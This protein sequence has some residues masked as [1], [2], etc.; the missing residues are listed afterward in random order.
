MRHSGKQMMSVLPMLPLPLLP[1]FLLLLLAAPAFPGEGKAEAGAILGVK[2]GED[3]VS[4]FVNGKLFTCYKFGPDQKYPYFWPVNGP[5]SG[6]SVTTESSQPYPHH[7]SLF[8]GCDR[9]NGGNYWQEGLERGQ[10]VSEGPRIIEATG[11]RILFTDRCFWI[12]PGGTPVIEDI[13]RITVTAPGAGKRI[14]DFEI[15]LRPLKPVT[16]ERTNHAL[17]SARVVPELSV[18]SGGKLV[19]AEGLSG[20]KE[21]YGVP[22]PWCDY[23]GGREGVVEGVAILQHPRNRWYP[24]TWFTR[25]YGFF[26]PTPMFWL[27]GGKLELP[28]NGAFTLRYRVLVHAGDCAAAEVGA[29]FARYARAAE[30]MPAEEEVASP[31]EDMKEETLTDPFSDFDDGG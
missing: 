18:K 29:L 1:V 30:K 16:I 13:R 25:D 5:V 4:V 7:H 22:S 28:Q 2:L 20:E 19:N 23:S 26:S 3:Q 14:I 17:F 8:F 31:K 10:I 21:T 12:R 11:R 27:D 15:T 9:V 6:K 24:A